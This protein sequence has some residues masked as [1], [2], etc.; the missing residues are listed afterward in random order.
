MKI[1]TKYNIGR[2]LYFIRDSRICREEVREIHAQV[3]YNGLGIYYDFGS[4]FNNT[5][6]SEGSLFVTKKDLLQYLEINCTL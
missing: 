3:N 2:K 4:P 6:I 1:N 5:R